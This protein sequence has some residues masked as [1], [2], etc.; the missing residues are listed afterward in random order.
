VKEP[1]WLP[2][3]LGLALGGAVLALY[4]PATGYDF[5]SF[6][7][8]RFILSNPLFEEGLTPRT[9]AAAFSLSALQDRDF[10]WIPLAW[11]S[12][13]ADRSLFGPAPWGFHLT[14]LLLFAAAFSV[15]FLALRGMTGRTG[16]SLFAAAAAAFHPMRVE[17]VAWVAERKDCLALLFLALAVAAYLRVARGGG[18]GWYA[19]LLLSHLLG[20]LAK[21]VLVVLPALLLALDLWPLGRMAPGEAGW[22][23]KASRL[24]AEKAPLLL[25]SSLFAAL[26]LL[27][28]GP[29]LVSLPLPQ[30][31]SLAVASPVIILR[32][33]FWPFDLHVGIFDPGQAP[34]WGA[35]LGAAAF[36]AGATWL[37]VRAAR[38]RPW[39]AA[40]W[41]W[42]LAAL[43]PGSGFFPNGTQWIADRFALFPHLGLFPALAWEAAA[44]A[45]G[46]RW[47]RA[48]GWGVA[49]ALLAALAAGARHQLPAWRDSVSLWSRSV[50]AAPRSAEYRQALGAALLARGD[51]GPGMEQ[52]AIALSLDPAHDLANFN[53]GFALLAQGRPEEAAPYF[54]RSRAASPGNP[55][56]SLFL[57]QIHLA[58]GRREQ[59]A[60]LYREV[61]DRFPGSAEALFSEGRLL[62]MAGDQAGARER[63]REAPASPA[64]DPA[65][66]R[67]LQRFLGG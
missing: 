46:W 7:D 56:A 32:K 53:M 55:R 23:R 31:V 64:V 35:T 20:L 29:N 41:F 30:K 9:A 11:T 37:A 26:T 3:V 22:L 8:L 19:L 13:L 39:V 63:Y 51:R 15:F 27:L 36:L 10:L 18:R 14:N 40:G 16:L 66:P 62:E 12:L 1:R 21:P 65:S 24:V 45:K 43:A 34:S 58:A 28:A 52:L 38:A 47:R 54:E 4:W 44:W 67:D 57:A 2:W 5:V 60:R 25:L 61:A 42:F 48:A 6:D 49:L 17:S 33:T 50:E 59:A